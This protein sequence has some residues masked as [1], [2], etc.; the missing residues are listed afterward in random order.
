M[1]I[2]I[3]SPVYG[4]P[5]LG[6]AQCLA[7]MIE[8][9][10]NAEIT[11][12]DGTRIVPLIRT[13]YWQSSSLVEARTSLLLNALDWGAHFVLWA[14]SDHTFP[15]EALVTLLGHNVGVVGCNYPQRAS[16]DLPTAGRKN[17]S[18]EMAH[19]FTRPGDSGLVEVD[20]L[21]LGLCLVNNTAFGQVRDVSSLFSTGPARSEDYRFFGNLR[22][23][24]VTVF[25]DQ[26]LSQKIGHIHE[27]VLTNAD[28]KAPS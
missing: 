4:D 9:T 13:R 16:P 2:A 14:D 22:A 27:H 1:K 11:A 18:G 23:A 10:K 20:Q 28:T 24:G 26:S 5:K 21:G 17:G 3:C 19:V 12:E 8:Y 6:F 15:Q 7:D 25:L